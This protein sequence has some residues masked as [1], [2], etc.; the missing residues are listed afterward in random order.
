MKIESKDHNSYINIECLGDPY[1][2][3]FFV[4][5]ELAKSSNQ[6][7]FKGHNKDVHFFKLD[8]FIKDL[9]HFITDRKIKPR[10]QGTYD[11]CLDVQAIEST[12]VWLTIYVGYDNPSIPFAT[13]KYGVLGGFEIDPE[14]LNQIVKSFKNFNR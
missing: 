13:I 5:T 2:S 11:F 4:E 12:R 14:F 7:Y 8:E 3:S 1:Y 9:D 6:Y 10:L